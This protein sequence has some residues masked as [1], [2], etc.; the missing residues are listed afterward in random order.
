MQRAGVAALYDR[1]LVR[2]QVYAVDGSGLGGDL[3]V[4]ALVCV[5]SDRPVIVAWRLLEGAASEKGKEAHVTRAL[6]RELHR[7]AVVAVS[8]VALRIALGEFSHEVLGSIRAVPHVLSQDGFTF[9]HPTIEDAARWVV[10]P[11]A[12][13][14]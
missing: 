11:Q 6:A 3:R 9:H 4:V 5:S 14:R 10:A 8:A 12:S 1:R 7:P 13:R 2:G